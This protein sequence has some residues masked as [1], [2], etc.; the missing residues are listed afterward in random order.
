MKTFGSTKDVA[1][2]L[3]V[4]VGRVRT[5]CQ[6]GRVADAQVVGRDWI[7]PMPPEIL[8]PKPAYRRPGLINEYTG[9]SRKLPRN[10]LT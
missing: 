9:I 7:I 8:P 6:Q 1:K 3:G 10:T 2:W 5:L 4:S